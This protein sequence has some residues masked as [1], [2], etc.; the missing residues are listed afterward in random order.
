MYKKPNQD[1]VSFGIGSFIFRIKLE[2]AK[3]IEDIYKSLKSELEKIP[4]LSKL[5]IFLVNRKKTA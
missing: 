2:E 3:C 5:E 1:Q 4:G